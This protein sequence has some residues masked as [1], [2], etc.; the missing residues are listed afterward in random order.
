[1]YII[2]LHDTVYHCHP[3]PSLIKELSLKQ[4]KF[5]YVNKINTTYNH[6]PKNLPYPFENG[7]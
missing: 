3:I 6:S 1:M 2:Y 7:V 4:K 5:K